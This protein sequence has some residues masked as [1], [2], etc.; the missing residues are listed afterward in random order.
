MQF[1][2]Y[3]TSKAARV[4]S[5][6]RSR[7]GKFRRA[8]S[9]LK[10]TRTGSNLTPGI[11]RSHPLVFGSSS[12]EFF[13]DLHEGSDLNAFLTGARRQL[14]ERAMRISE[15]NRTK[16]ATLLG[17]TPQAVSQYLLKQST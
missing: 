17:I 12:G 9:L 16:A 15:G 2:L 5:L 8:S 6:D 14:I 10:T 4:Y 3:G 7:Y 11:S 13:P 1:I